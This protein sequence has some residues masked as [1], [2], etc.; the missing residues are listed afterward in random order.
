[1]RVPGLHVRMSNRIVYITIR[2]L[3]TFFV[4]I[5]IPGRSFRKNGL[6]PKEFG[7]GILPVD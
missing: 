5:T 1:M 4:I 6:S 3:I 7:E 2:K